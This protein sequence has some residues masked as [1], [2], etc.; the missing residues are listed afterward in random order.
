M[1]KIFAKS[2]YRFCTDPRLNEA[3]LY[4]KK[5]DANVDEVK[6]LKKKK[7]NKIRFDISVY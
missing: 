4:K 1:E 2:K 3:Y 5:S 7:K 6:H